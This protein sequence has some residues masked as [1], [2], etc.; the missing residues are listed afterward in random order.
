MDTTQRPKVTP[1][2]FFLWLGAMVTLYWSATALILLIH[3]YIEVLF[4]DVATSTYYFDPYSGT[5]R[6]AIA[7]LVVVFPLYVW[8]MRLLHS[9]IRKIPEKKELWVRRWLVYLTLFVAGLTIAVDLIA[10]IYTFLEGDLTTR[11]LLKALTILV[12][13]GGGFYYYLHELKGTWEKREKESKMIGAVVSLVVLASIVGGFFIIGSPFEE[14]LLKIDERKVSDLQTI[15][16]QMVTYYQ[17]KEVLPTTLQD[18][19]D[20]LSGFII[21]MDPETGE[22][23]TYEATGEH[24]FN[25]CAMFNAPSRELPGVT[26]PAGDM[27]N[28][29]WKHPAGEACFERT[30]DPDRYPPFD[31]KNMPSAF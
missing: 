18:L 31:G 11:F 27:F 24:S 2:D 15:Q 5:I 6:F 19:A 13:L 30:I 7:S 25:L 28:E 9:D 20:P 8:L 4:P 14:R 1:K 23:Y 22:A 17:Q 16:Y 10:V 21:P 12:V 26:R 29:N 3:E